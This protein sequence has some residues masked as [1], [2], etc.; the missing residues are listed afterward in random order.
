MGDQALPLNRMK[1]SLISC[2]MLMLFCTISMSNAKRYLVETVDNSGKF[3]HNV[4]GD[5]RRKS[6]RI[7]GQREGCSYFE[8]GGQRR[9]EDEWRRRQTS[10]P[11]QEELPEDCNES[12]PDG[13]Q[14]GE[15]AVLTDGEDYVATAVIVAGI[16]LL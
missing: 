8:I 10:D 7:G 1:I 14:Q 6:N 16:G 5:Q 12:L 11:S 3:A 4:I 15:E 13:T 9:P 2:G